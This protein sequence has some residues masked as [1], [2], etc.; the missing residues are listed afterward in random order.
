MPTTISQRQRDEDD[1]AHLA[2]NKIS[3]EGGIEAVTKAEMEA[4]RA[5]LAKKQATL[6]GGGIVRGDLNASDEAYLV[7]HGLRLRPALDGELK[8]FKAHTIA[9]RKPWVLV[10]KV[11]DQIVR[12]AL[13]FPSNASTAILARLP[14]MDD[15]AVLAEASGTWA[16][17]VG[18]L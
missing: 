5:T 4:G 13:S 1:A 18:V 14:R 17:V 7:G 6:F 8:I 16:Q 10:R 9:G 3:A 15:E 11:D 12:V 2:R